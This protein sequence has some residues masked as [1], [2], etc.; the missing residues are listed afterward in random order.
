MKVSAVLVGVNVAATLS[1][2]AQH[3]AFAQDG[4]PSSTAD[5]LKSSLVEPSSQE[6][7]QLVAGPA[8]PLSQGRKV[9][10]SDPRSVA[11]RKALS[12][13]GVK[14]RPFLANRR[15]PTKAD[16]EVSLAPQTA[17]MD[18]SNQPTT[19]DGGVSEYTPYYSSV[20]TYDQAAMSPRGKFVLKSHERRVESQ[21]LRAAARVAS[22]YTRP[23]APRAVPGS[24]PAVPGRVG[25]PCAEQAM[26][27]IAHPQQQQQQFVNPNFNQQQRVNQP[28]NFAQQPQHF[29]FAPSMGPTQN[30]EPL[31]PQRLSP[32]E[33]LEMN[34]LV[35]T[36]CIQNG[37]N[38]N[39][40]GPGASDLYARIGPPP[41]PLSLIPEDAMKG[42]LKGARNRKSAIPGQA[43][44]SFSNDHTSA[45]LPAGGFRSYLRSTT[46]GYTNFSRMPA[47][48]PQNIHPISQNGLHRGKTQPNHGTKK[49]NA[50]FQS[51]KNEAMTYP[52]YKSQMNFGS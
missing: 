9:S 14:L 13:K 52:P 17:A 1:V 51:V 22:T 20:D 21:R 25:Y 47:A 50:G 32:Q 37:V 26:P 39:V 30:D 42:F 46:N 8:Q 10:I 19:L 27:M 31:P 16:M 43:P 5:F 24:A 23:V 3:P 11:T 29:N 38:P 15:L 34:K 44:M 6:P 45:N 28:L 7:V 40:V 41:F 4:R 36:A 48:Y 33:Q 12:A 49:N 35:E 2:A 18:Y